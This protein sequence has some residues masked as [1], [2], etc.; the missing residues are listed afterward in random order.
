MIELKDISFSIGKKNILDNV[1]LSL[2]ENCIHVFLGPSGCG[3][4][5]LLRLVAGLEKP[6]SGCLLKNCI[7][8]TGKLGSKVGFV[9]QNLALWPHMTAEKHLQFMLRGSKIQNSDK[10][11]ALLKQ[12]KLDDR[13]QAY[14]H[15]LSGGEKQRLAIVRAVAASPEILLMDEPFSNLDVL[16]RAEL[17]QILR[18]LVKNERMTILYVT[19]NIYEALEL[20]DSVILFNAHM[21]QRILTKEELSL[22]SQAEIINLYKENQNA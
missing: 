3:K 22:M 18:E 10:I 6:S 2:P 9:F 12:V 19:H 11:S 20:A 21:K 5:S 14:P 7:D 16:L 4:T 1:S 8:V 17:S 13:S 15:E